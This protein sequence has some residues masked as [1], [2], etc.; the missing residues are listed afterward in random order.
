V[1][2]VPRVPRSGAQPAHDA[3]GGRVRETSMTRIYLGVILV[4]VLTTLA[5]LWL[6]S[7]YTR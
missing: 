3:P 6:E 5:L 7:A 2:S 4:Q 1:T